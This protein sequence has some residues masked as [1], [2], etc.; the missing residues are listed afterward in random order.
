MLAPIFKTI[1]TPAVRAIVGNRIYGKGT[2]PQGTPLPYITW[3]TVAG[4]PYANLSDAPNADNDTIQIDCWAGPDD[5]QEGICDQ[6]AKHV[7]DAVDAAGQAC[8]IIIDTREADTKL[9]HIGL[10][11]EFIHNR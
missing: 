4:D 7:R 9:F 5:D 2:A 11:V 8:R 3:F 10:Q 1:D 6:L